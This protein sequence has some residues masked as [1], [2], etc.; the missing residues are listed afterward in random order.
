L[1]A[2]CRGAVVSSTS[3]FHAPQASQRPCQRGATAP[4]LWQ[5]NEVRDFAILDIVISLADQDKPRHCEERSGEAI[6]RAVSLDCFASLAM[7]AS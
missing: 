1:P 5:I 6:Q 4:Q 7:T 3:E 2:P